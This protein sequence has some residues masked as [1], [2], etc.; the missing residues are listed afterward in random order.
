[1]HVNVERGKAALNVR[2][3]VR[4]PGILAGASFIAI[5][6]LCAPQQAI[7]AC[8]STGASGV[9][10]SS[11]GGEGVHTATANSATPRPSGGGYSR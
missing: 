2:S 9:H 6:S 4:L 3:A 1:M 8:G 7:A 5:L 11:G 10:P